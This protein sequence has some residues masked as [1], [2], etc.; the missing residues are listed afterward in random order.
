MRQGLSY[1]KEFRTLRHPSDQYKWQKGSHPAQKREREGRD[2]I[3]DK[4][5]GRVVPTPQGYAYN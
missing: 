2:I 5:C 1:G 4:G 3:H